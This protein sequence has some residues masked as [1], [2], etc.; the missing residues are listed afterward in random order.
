MKKQT[1]LILILMLCTLSLQA[2]TEHMNFAGIPLTGTIDQFQKKLIA[3][4]YRTQTMLNKQLPVGTRVFKGTFAGKDGNVAVY[5]DNVTKIVYGAKVYFDQLTS[6]RAKTELDQLKSLLSL[7]Y[8]EDQIADGTDESG[9]ATFTVN[10]ELGS[11]YCYMME[12]AS[13]INYPYNWSTH[14]EFSDLANSTKHTS[15]IL[16][17]F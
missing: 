12:D 16:N 6:D 13:A 3:K 9:H 5:Y 15:E 14:A 7:K 17:D 4:G 1:I 2:Q 10:T 11:I 8:G